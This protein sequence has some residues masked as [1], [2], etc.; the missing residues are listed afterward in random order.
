MES[1]IETDVLVAG[2]GTAGAAAAVAAARKGHRVLLV[3]E[4]NCLGGVSTAGGV[5][6]YF[7]YPEGLGDIFART[8]SELEKFGAVEPEPPE[9]AYPG[10]HFNG[11]YLKIIWQLLAEEAGVDLLLHASVVGADV[12]DGRV[13]SVR[14]ASC[15]QFIDVAARYFIDATGE[16]DLAALAGAEYDMGDPSEGLTLHM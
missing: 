7:A 8:V 6:E 2:G 5:N 10:W 13:S 3:E 4:G 15:S 16:G 12:E 1:R 9:G 11:E 14:V